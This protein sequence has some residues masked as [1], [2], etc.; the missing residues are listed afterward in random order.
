MVLTSF[1]SVIDREQVKRRRQKRS[2]DLKRDLLMSN[3][4]DLVKVSRILSAVYERYNPAG[5]RPNSSTR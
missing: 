1:A 4:R 5:G 3:E 2:S